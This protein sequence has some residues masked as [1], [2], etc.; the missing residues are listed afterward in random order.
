[1]AREGA[2]ASN[3]M[4]SN[5]GLGCPVLSFPFTVSF[6]Y[7]I[8]ATLVG[9]APLSWADSTDSKVSG[10]YVY[11]VSSDLNVLGQIDNGT[12]VGVFG[13]TSSYVNT[14]MHLMYSC[15]S[16]TSRVL[17]ANGSVSSTFTASRTVDT[18]A[19]RWG[20][21]TRVIA[22]PSSYI[23][24]GH[25]VSEIG[26]WNIALN[27]TDDLT[28]LYNNRMSP[29]LVKPKNLVTYAPL[30]ESGSVARDLIGGRNLSSFGT[31]MPYKDSDPLQYLRR[32]FPGFT[33]GV[34][35]T[36]SPYNSIFHGSVF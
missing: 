28:S 23:S 18:S 19:D 7:R 10:F 14:N 12:D 35:A 21:G 13:A 2:S 26:I 34:A 33:S 3:Y 5:T 22:T 24:A 25:F 9:G 4:A 16:S 11:N 20:I 1:M 8:P 15:T 36:S 29:L 30:N 17:A 32:S 6:W 27:T 31:G